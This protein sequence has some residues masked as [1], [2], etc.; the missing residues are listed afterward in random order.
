MVSDFFYPNCGGVENHVYQLSQ[1]LMRNG[2]KVVVVT[3]AYNKICAGVRY[4]TNGLKVMEAAYDH[5]EQRYNVIP[6]N[7]STTLTGCLGS[8][9]AL[10]PPFSDRCTC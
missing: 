6:T 7:R 5:R 3:H 4:L 10:S 9:K 1:C 2:H 8:C